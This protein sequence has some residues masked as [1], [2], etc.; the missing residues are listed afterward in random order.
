MIVIVSL[1]HLGRSRIETG[2]ASGSSDDGA[3]GDDDDSAIGA[4]MLVALG[5]R[6]TAAAV[7]VV[8]K[9]EARRARA[10]VGRCIVALFLFFFFFFSGV[11]LRIPVTKAP[12]GRRVGQR[13]LKY[14][15][16]LSAWWLAVRRKEKSS[17]RRGGILRSLLSCL[18]PWWSRYHP[19]DR[20]LR[21]S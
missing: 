6:A 13:S 9:R 12:N 4:A 20:G 5:G 17:A 1:F 10:A 7:A 3:D 15:S 16:W 11:W 2:T 14:P 18:C 19:G 8:V 21:M